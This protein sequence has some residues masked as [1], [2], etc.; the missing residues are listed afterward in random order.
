MLARAGH[1]HALA[2][3]AVELDAAALEVSARARGHSG[4]AQTPTTSAQHP[5]TLVCE[6]TSQIARG[7]AFSSLSLLLFQPRSLNCACNVWKEATSDREGSPS[8]HR[9]VFC[10]AKEYVFELFRRMCRVRLGGF[11]CSGLHFAKAC[12]KGGMSRARAH[13]NCGLVCYGRYI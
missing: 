4:I 6:P 11:F 3:W 13:S 7:L 12:A 2:Q 8:T 9:T 10:E 5:P 1:V